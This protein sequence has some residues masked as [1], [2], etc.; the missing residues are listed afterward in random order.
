MKDLSGNENTRESVP[1]LITP[2]PANNFELNWNTNN[3]P[4]TYVIYSYTQSG[5]LA[6]AHPSE[7]TPASKRTALCACSPAESTDAPIVI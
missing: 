6:T 1:S 7:A 2:I 5:E 3:Y 4:L